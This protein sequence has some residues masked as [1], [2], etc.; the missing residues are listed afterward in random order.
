MGD[1]DQGTFGLDGPIQVGFFPS[2]FSFDRYS[3]LSRRPSVKL[4]KLL[5]GRRRHFFSQIQLGKYETWIGNSKFDAGPFPPSYAGGGVLRRAASDALF[6]SSA[7]AK[8]EYVHGE[9]KGREKRIAKFPCTT[10]TH[11]FPSPPPIPL[12]SDKRAAILLF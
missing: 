1:D 8:K 9:G 5:E 7:F 4:K 3:L 11:P 2:P 6:T 12:R 10:T